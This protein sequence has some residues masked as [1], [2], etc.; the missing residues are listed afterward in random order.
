MAD[1]LNRDLCVALGKF[2]MPTAQ[3]GGRDPR[4]RRARWRHEPCSSHTAAE[5]SRALQRVQTG[6]PVFVLLWRGGN[7]LFVQMRKD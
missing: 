2:S 6:Q 3:R 7:N 5:A 4:A 1:P